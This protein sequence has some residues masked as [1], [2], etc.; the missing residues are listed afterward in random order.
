METIRTPLTD[1]FGIKVPIMLAGMG[2][3]AGPELAAAVTNAGGIGVIGGV[4]F[5][6]DMLRRNIKELKSYLE[7][8]N[9]PWGVDLLLPQVG[10]NARKTN[11]DYTQGKLGELIDIM[12]EEKCRL[13]VSAVGIPPQW[14]V[15][16]L[17]KA[18]IPVMNMIGAPKHVPKALSVGVDLICAQGSEAGGHT[19][20]ISTSVLIPK[21]VDLCRGTKSPLTGKDVVV[22]GAGG[23]ADG[24]GLAMALAL[25][26]SGVWVGT[27][28]V[29]SKEA[30]VSKR[31]QEA[32]IK[33]EHGDTVRTLI[34]SG[35]PMRVLRTPYVDNWESKRAGDIA[36]LTGQG[37]VPHMYTMDELKKTGKEPTPEQMIE[38]MPL[39]MGQAAG[40][41]SDVLPAK[42][43]VE[44]MMRDAVASIKR[45]SGSVAKL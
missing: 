1:L 6:P 29:N 31:F 33:A 8:K 25:G 32:I 27:R 21:V 5:A 44:N 26:A 18:G 19:G 12:I 35:R 3:V 10:G 4:S 2:N 40:N 9:A 22:V 43:I 28:F 39:I 41:I 42:A 16:K 15:E 34:Y 13:F 14:A 17:H 11:K 20:D 36:R 37:H 24:R 45:M 30:S 7:D 23:I 38:T